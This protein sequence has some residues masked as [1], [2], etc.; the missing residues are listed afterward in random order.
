MERV[1]TLAQRLKL[2]REENKMTLN[3]MAALTGIPA[4]TLNRYELAQRAPKI[5][6]ANL[7]AEKLNIN[8][9]WLQGYDIPINEKLP[10]P[11]DDEDRQLNEEII[12]LLLRLRPEELQRVKD[13][14]AGIL[15]SR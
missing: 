13:F 15:A 2:Y 3:D 6:M 12:Q 4:Q 11:I 1:S 10:T 9:L 14:A 5:N 8:P 7:I